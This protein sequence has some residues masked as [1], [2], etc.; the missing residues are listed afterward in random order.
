MKRALILLTL[1]ILDRQ[2]LAQ[3]VRR[4]TDNIGIGISTGASTPPKL[5]IRERD[6]TKRNMIDMHYSDVP[7][8]AAPA[9][10]PQNGMVKSNADLHLV[11]ANAGN[12]YLKTGGEGVDAQTRMIVTNNGHVGI[13]TPTPQTTLDV[14]GNAKFGPAGNGY[15]VH[16]NGDAASTGWV[17]FYKANNNRLGYIGASPDDMYYVAEN[18]AKHVFIGRRV[19]ITSPDAILE[20]NGKI[21]AKKVKVMPYGPWPDFVF[22]KNY[23]LPD[24]QELESYIRRHKHLPDIPSQK[25]VAAGGIDLGEMNRKLLQKVE[26]LTLYIIDMKKE[27]QQ[28]AASILELKKKK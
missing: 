27:S 1:F 26:E 3:N 14:N 8:G 6:T 24:L 25:E 2:V 5:S 19:L 17:G 21:T 15:T 16:G 22:E 13:G 7:G 23:M 20:V 10:L 28:Q 12:I 18:D 4:N 9:V 11:A